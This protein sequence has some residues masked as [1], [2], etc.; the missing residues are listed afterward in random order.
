MIF[1]VTPH[2]LTVQ[3]SKRL[4]SDVVLHQCFYWYSGTYLV[5]IQEQDDEYWKVTLETKAGIFSDENIDVL[6]AKICQDLIDFKLRVL[7][8]AETKVIRELLVAKA[9]SHRESETGPL[10]NVSDP[11]GFNPQ[12]IVTHD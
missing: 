2:Q 9:F 6:K 3:L 11:I 12:D 10:T 8:S 4:Y 7:V 5:V 1:I